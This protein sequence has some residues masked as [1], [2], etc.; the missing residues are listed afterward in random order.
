MFLGVSCLD[1][2][3]GSVR[4]LALT[5]RLQS[6]FRSSAAHDGHSEGW[7]YYM[8]LCDSPVVCRQF[9]AGNDAHE[10]LEAISKALG[11]LGEGEFKVDGITPEASGNAG[12]VK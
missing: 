8:L 5:Y 4:Q 10:K 7:P 11:R 1:T 2:C 9:R 3:Y 12:L 6:S